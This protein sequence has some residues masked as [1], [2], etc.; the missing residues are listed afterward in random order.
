M[1][2]IMPALCAGRF[3]LGF[4]GGLSIMGCSVFNAE[5]VPADLLGFIGTGMNCGIISS[6]LL[7]IA[8][9]NTTLPDIDDQHAI[10]QNTTWRI[11]FYAPGI[12]AAI[13]SVLWV[14]LIK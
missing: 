13:S 4:A 5:T 6:L 3:M 11:G 14:V 12:L 10:D 7:T 2:L 9:Q 8:I 1:W